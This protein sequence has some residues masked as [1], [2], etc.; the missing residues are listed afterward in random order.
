M[1]VETVQNSSFLERG[2]MQMP[3]FGDPC[4][5]RVIDVAGVA[6]AAVGLVLLLTGFGA[7]AG[8]I[9]I[10]VGL[11]LVFIKD[12]QDR[13]KWSMDKV[14]HGELPKFFWE[15]NDYYYRS[16][17]RKIELG[18]AMF[19]ES[20]KYVYQPD[21]TTL[22]NSRIVAVLSVKTDPGYQHTII[23]DSLS[24]QFFWYIDRSTNLV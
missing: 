17:Y 23:H 10:A 22:I 24:G 1:T 14:A 5:Q 16:G 3:D 6:I 20:G 9:L 18:H 21:K 12:F 19:S 8:I 15:G 7:P 13:G 11:A 4:L 2:G